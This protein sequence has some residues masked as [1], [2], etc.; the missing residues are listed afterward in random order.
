M[1][2]GVTAN[3]TLSRSASEGKTRIPRWRVGVVWRAGLIFCLACILTPSPVLAQKTLRWK[4]KAGDELPVIIEQRT[5]STVSFGSKSAKTTLD[6]TLE[7]LWK[8]EAADARQAKITQT[9]KRI[10]VKMQAGEGGPISYDSA[11]KETP[12]GDAKNLA[13]AVQPLLGEGCVIV[14]TMDA[15]GDVLSAE[16]SAKL[17]ELWNGAKTET[18][19]KRG[20]DAAKELLK[21]SLVLLPEKAVA[22]DDSGKLKWSSEREVQIPIGKVKQTT[23]FTYAGEADSGGHKLDKIEFSSRLELAAGGAKNLKLTLKEQKQTGHALF[24]AEQ[25]RVVSAEQTQKLVTEAPYR[26]TIITVTVESTVK[27]QIGPAPK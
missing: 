25:G 15:R 4:L 20:S 13:A 24:S 21:R 8:V 17:A 5:V 12:I 16:P 22:A 1:F 18:S 2:S 3:S 23:E 26:E 11:A 7:T 27:T 6:M 9:V 19:A 10:A 14:V